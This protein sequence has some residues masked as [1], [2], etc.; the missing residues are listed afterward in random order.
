MTNR[1]HSFQEWFRELESLAKKMG[2]AFTLNPDLWHWEYDHGM[3]PQETLA[4]EI[5]D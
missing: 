2:F 4:K 5:A 1:T 3:T